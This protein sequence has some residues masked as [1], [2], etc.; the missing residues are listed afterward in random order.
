MRESLASFRDSWNVNSFRSPDRHAVSDV[1]LS[2]QEREGGAVPRQNCRM[3]TCFDLDRCEGR[4]FRVYVY[5]SD[6][7][8]RCSV[9]YRRVLRVIRESRLATEDP[10]Q[11]CVFVLALDTLDRD[12]LSGDFVPMLNQ[13]VTALPLWNNGRNHIVFNLFSGTWP[14]YNEDLMFNVG[15][16]ILAKASMSEEN[17]RDGFDVSL[18]LFPKKHPERGGE[19]GLVTAY[20][21]PA[22]KKYLLAFKVSQAWW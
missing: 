9:A 11:A 2:V 1:G 13:K 18:P 15:E 4:P 22:V 14:D 20:N 19:E 6:D 17:F 12:Q 16:A 10:D 3:T 5:P 7:S 8:V 21:F